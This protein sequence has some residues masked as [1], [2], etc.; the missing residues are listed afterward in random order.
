MGAGVAEL[1]C[2]ALL[3][4]LLRLP[5]L[6]HHRVG[7]PGRVQQH[8]HSPPMSQGTRV[9]QGGAGDHGREE[10]DLGLG[11]VEGGEVFEEAEG[12]VEEG[13]L[14]GVLAVEEGDGD[15]GAA[16]QHP[17]PAHVHQLTCPNEGQLEGGACRTRCVL[18]WVSEKEGAG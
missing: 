4:R 13:G 3:E 16:V 2:E 1:G 11:Q 18:F 10:G 7:R 6:L 5:H 9:G 17:L 8:L 15:V 14:D 12:A